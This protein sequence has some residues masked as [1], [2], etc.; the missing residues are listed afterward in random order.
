MHNLQAKEI[1]TTAKI[2]NKAGAASIR[3][4]TKEKVELNVNYCNQTRN[5]L[6]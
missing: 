6:N 5:N 4:I 3:N 1:F 2:I